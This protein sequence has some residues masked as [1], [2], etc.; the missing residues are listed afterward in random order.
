MSWIDTFLGGGPDY[1][2]EDRTIADVQH[3][4]LNAGLGEGLPLR[5]A[6]D[7][8]G[9]SAQFMSDPKL[10]AMAV[11]AIEGPHFPSRA[12]GTAE[13]LVIE[14]AR[15]AMAGSAMVDSFA[16]GAV[17]VVLHNLDW[18]Q[19]L[20]PILVHAQKVYGHGFEFSKPGARTIMVSK[21]AKTLQ[22]TGEPQAVPSEPLAR[23][24]QLA[25]KAPKKP[26]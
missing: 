9:V 18:P 3:L 19:L 2:A 24:E 16:K 1:A 23:L 4:F 6:Q 10:F 8:A 7:F 12:E 21:V 22:S 17:R 14:D 20:W 15:I 5:Q 13:H 11:A 25:S 26:A